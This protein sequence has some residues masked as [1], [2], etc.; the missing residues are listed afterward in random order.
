MCPPMISDNLDITCTYNG[1]KVDCSK[2]SIPGTTLSPKCKS[3]HTVTNGIEI[4]LSIHC[5]HDGTWNNK[6]YSCVPSNLF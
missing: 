4:P 1:E 2:Q 3:T 5:Q 6:L